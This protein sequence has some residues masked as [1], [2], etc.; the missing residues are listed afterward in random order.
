MG[1]ASGLSSTVHRCGLICSQ[2]VKQID[3][4]YCCVGAKGS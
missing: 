1:S 3:K 4:Q 2:V